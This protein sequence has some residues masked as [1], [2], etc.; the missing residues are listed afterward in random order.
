[1]RYDELYMRFGTNRGDNTVYYLLAMIPV[2]NTKIELERM[3]SI[4]RFDCGVHSP[5][6]VTAIGNVPA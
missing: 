4:L 3:I 6:K 1:M 5:S 2:L